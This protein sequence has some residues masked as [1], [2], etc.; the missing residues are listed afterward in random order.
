MSKEIMIMGLRVVAASAHH[1]H[2]PV[3]LCNAR[4]ED[5]EHDNGKKGKEG[6]EEGA[7]DPVVGTLTDVDADHVLEYLADG[8]EKGGSEE[9]D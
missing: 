6:F 1:W 4:P 5:P 3:I 2:R 8:E 9:V 7:I